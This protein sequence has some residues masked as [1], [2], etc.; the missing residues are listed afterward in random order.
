MVHGCGGV[1]A[2]GCAAFIDNIADSSGNWLGSNSEHGIGA[3]SAM[4]SRFSCNTNP[5][6][7]P[8]GVTVCVTTDLATV[9]KQRFINSIIRSNDYY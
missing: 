2:G 7:M 1:V 6:I 9:P 8:C 4:P 3:P 5:N